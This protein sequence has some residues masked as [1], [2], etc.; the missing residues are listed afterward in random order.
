MSPR[1]FRVNGEPIFIQ[2]G[3]WIMSDGLPRLPEK[4]YKRDIKFHADMNFNMTR[5]WGSGLAETCRTFIENGPFGINATCLE[6][7]FK[8]CAGYS[9]I[10]C[11][12]G[13]GDK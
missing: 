7:F 3:N 2:G 5:C 1:L 10:T 9:V 11:I 13:I 4:C 6:T 8:S 12:F